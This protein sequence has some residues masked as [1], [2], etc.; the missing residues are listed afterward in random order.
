MA[1]A[2][3]TPGQMSATNAHLMVAEGW[4]IIYFQAPNRGECLRLILTAAGEQFEDVRVEFPAGLNQYK[5]A[6]VGD[7]SPLPFD[8]CPI[9]QHAQ[10]GASIGQTAAAAMYIGTQTGLAPTDANQLAQAQSAAIGIQEM[11]NALFYS[12]YIPKMICF[13][14]CCGGCGGCC[15][16]CCSCYTRC[17]GCMGMLCPCCPGFCGCSKPINNYHAQ[18]ANYERMLRVN[19]KSQESINH[20]APAVTFLVGD[21]LSYVDICL[22]DLVQA[23]EEVGFFSEGDR[24]AYPLISQLVD[25]VAQ[26]PTIVE[27]MS[28]REPRFK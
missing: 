23:I 27:Y 14:A 17:G 18:M 8:Q 13:K 22:Y 11:Y 5:S 21:K 19:L 9:V 6:T 15:Y 1:D 25:H 10:T 26:I 7:A 2:M 3:S 12:T 20:A 4:R 28:R 16:P 24:S